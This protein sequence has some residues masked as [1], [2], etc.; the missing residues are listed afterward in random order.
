MIERITLTP[1]N[2]V[3]ILL[4]IYVSYN[5]F[6]LSKEKQLSLLFYPY[7]AARGKNLFSSVISMFTHSSWEHLALNMFALYLLGPAVEYGIGSV[8]FFFLYFLSGFAADLALVYKYK[9]VKNYCALG[10]SGATSGV[11]FAF[12]VMN[13]FELLQFI[14]IPIPFPA[15]LFGLLY[16]IGSTIQAKRSNDHIAHEA[17]IGGAIGGALF[18]FLLKGF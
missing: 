18:M 7:M 4:T 2:Y 14:L 15:W 16:L 1:V 5:Y 10:A 8:A 17:H 6:K 9:D 12:I 13:P 3:L 11:V